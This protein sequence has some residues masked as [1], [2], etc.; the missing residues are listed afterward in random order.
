MAWDIRE[1]ELKDRGIN[2]RYTRP[3][4]GSRAAIVLSILLACGHGPRSPE[5]VATLRT[6]PAVTASPKS[7]TQLEHPARS[8]QAHE[9]DESTRDEQSDQ[10]EQ[11]YDSFRKSQFVVTFHLSETSR[12]RNVQETIIHLSSK[13]Y[14]SLTVE[15]V[16][17]AHD[18]IQAASLTA[19]RNWIGSGGHI[20]PASVKAVWLF[21]E[22]FTVPA[23][24]NQMKYF[25]DAISEINAAKPMIWKMI[26]METAIPGMSFHR[27]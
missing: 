10:D 17:G 25:V 16:L 15:L 7:L 23:D 6:S 27:T 5:P 22:Q 9:P 12:D 11:R 19:Q 8:L 18:K 4:R 13:D 14:E 1:R 26:L 2:A 24:L 20:N 21:L 3:L